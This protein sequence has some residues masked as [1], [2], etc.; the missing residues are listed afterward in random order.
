MDVKDGTAR[1]TLLGHAARG[2]KEVPVGNNIGIGRVLMCA[3][4][5]PSR[6]MCVIADRA[7]RCPRRLDHA[8]PVITRA[9]L[10]ITRNQ[11][12]LWNPSSVRRLSCLGVGRG[13]R[14]GRLVDT[15]FPRTVCCK[16]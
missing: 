5:M 14:E 10:S 6:M 2:V 13:G 11:E 7:G 8:R 16:Q 4:P 3:W 15:E 1:K 9:C 12:P